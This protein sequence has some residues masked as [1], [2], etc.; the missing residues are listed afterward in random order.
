VKY[1]SLYAPHQVNC[2]F[3][4][5]QRA[6]TISAICSTGIQLFRQSRHQSIQFEGE[7]TPHYA[8]EFD[9]VF[10]HTPDAD[11]AKEDH[12]EDQDSARPFHQAGARYRFSSLRRVVTKNSDNHEEGS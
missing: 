3:R 1:R 6:Q 9:S 12:S 5:G 4:A 7:R 8:S 11:G 2:I 10:E